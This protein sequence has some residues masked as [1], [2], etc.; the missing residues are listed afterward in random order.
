ME[1]DYMCLTAIIFLHEVSPSTLAEEEKEEFKY[2]TVFN[3]VA[4]AVTIYL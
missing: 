4:V 3:V 1:I 2:F